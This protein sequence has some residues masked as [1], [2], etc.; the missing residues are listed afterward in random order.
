MKVNGEFVSGVE[1]WASLSVMKT[2]EDII[3]DFY[4]KYYNQ[5]GEL[6][7]PGVTA[8]QVRASS[9]IQHR[10]TFPGQ[11]INGLISVFSFRTISLEI[12]HGK[13]T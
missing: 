8:D 11:P 9:Q 12:Q 4:Y 6:I 3:G 13:C 1:S 5:A 2:E 10:D 7:I